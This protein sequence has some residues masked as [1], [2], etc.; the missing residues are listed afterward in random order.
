MHLR[1]DPRQ[2]E[3]LCREIGHVA[4]EEDKEGLYNPGVRRKAGREGSQDAVDD[5]HHDSSH[6]D[7]EKRNHTKQCVADSHCSLVGKFL[8]EVI[9]N[10]QNKRKDLHSTATREPL[11]DFK[12]SLHNIPI[13][14]I[15][16]NT[17]SRKKRAGL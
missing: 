4:V 11:I 5:A 7:H 1:H 3:D 10:L 6:G 2:M 8:K 15:E 12:L 16:I 9:Q 17:Y 13:E 14:V